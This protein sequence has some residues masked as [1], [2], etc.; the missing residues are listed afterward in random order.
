LPIEAWTAHMPF[1]PAMSDEPVSTSGSDEV[2][3]SIL[4]STPMP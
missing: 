3:E 1:E 2:L 4:S